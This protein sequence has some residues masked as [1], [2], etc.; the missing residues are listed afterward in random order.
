MSDDN[1][2]I[3]DKFAV[4]VNRFNEVYQLEDSGDLKPIGFKEPE[5]SIEQFMKRTKIVKH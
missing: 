5:E 3:C 2:I 4:K 1:L